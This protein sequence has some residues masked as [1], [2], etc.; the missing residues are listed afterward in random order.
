MNGAGGGAG[1]G[2]F[3]IGAALTS[4]GRIGASGIGGPAQGDVEA[5]FSASELD[6]RPRAIYQAPPS[7]PQEL[8]KRG[9]QGTVQIVFLVDT[10][11]KVVS[12]KVE[13]STNPAFEKPAL[14]S[15]RQWRFEAGTRNGEKV[16]FKM[17]VPISFSGGQAS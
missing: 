13:R 17:R 6:Q 15:V 10:D 14:D 5:I 8:R 1:A 9:V 4:G 16:R 2:G 11:G 12:P 3:G 7:Y